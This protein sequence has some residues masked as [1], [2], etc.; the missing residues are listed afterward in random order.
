[1][2]LFGYFPTY[3]L[4]NVYAGCL[5]D[6]L[7][8]ALPGLDQQ[9]TKGDLA[10]ALGWLRANLQTHGGLRPP[11]ETVEHATGTLVSEGPLLAYLEAKYRALYGV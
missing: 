7:R 11:R 10:P 4:G 5:H 2:G 8:G 9:L 1:V 6:A 3:S